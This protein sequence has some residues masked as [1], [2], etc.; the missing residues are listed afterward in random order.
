MLNSGVALVL[1][2]IVTVMFL[3]ATWEM[4]TFNPASRLMPAL[5]IVPGLP[6]ALWLVFRGFREFRNDFE[7]DA[8]E[9]WILAA[10]VI[11]AIAVWAIGISI[12]TIALIAWMLLARAKMR[13]WTSLIYGA[14]VFAIVR[15]LFDLLRGDAPAGA[16]LNFS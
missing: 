11:Y 8:N 2:G 14:A 1:A 15:L 7:R 4:F 9:L 16:I 12:P 5:A 6:L 3:Y 10:F 13:W